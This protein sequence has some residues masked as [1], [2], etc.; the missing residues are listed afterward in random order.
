[1]NMHEYKEYIQ[2]MQFG[3]LVWKTFDERQM[4]NILDGVWE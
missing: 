3:I 2:K 4:D 1:M